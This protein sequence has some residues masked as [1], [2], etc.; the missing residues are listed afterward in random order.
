ME[1]AKKSGQLSVAS[2]R[3]GGMGYETFLWFLRI[4]LDDII[5]LIES[6]E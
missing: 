4:K 2:C 3:Y 1:M 6:I 5:R